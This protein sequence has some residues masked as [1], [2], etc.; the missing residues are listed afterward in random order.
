MVS[1]YLVVNHGNSGRAKLE[2]TKEAM[3]G[4]QAIPPSLLP[5]GFTIKPSTQPE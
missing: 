4:E 1:G 3:E 2:I 5:G